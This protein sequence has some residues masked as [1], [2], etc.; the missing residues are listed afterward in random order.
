M[1]RPVEPQR[2]AQ[3][4]TKNQELKQISAEPQGELIFSFPFREA[5]D[6][7][8]NNPN[9]VAA[10][11]SRVRVYSVLDLVV[12]EIGRGN[13][14]TGLNRVAVARMSGAD[15]LEVRVDTNDVAIQIDE[16]AGDSSVRMSAAAYSGDSCC[17]VGRWL[18]PFATGALFG[19]SFVQ[20]VVTEITA[21]GLPGSTITVDGVVY[22]IGLFAFQLRPPWGSLVNPRIAT[23]A[24]VL[25]VRIERM[26]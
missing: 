24:G 12:T 8:A 18:P 9:G 20:G 10:V 11:G 7:Y 2:D 19:P 23:S 16:A 25:Q 13:I 5:L 17:G 6:V 1:A 21:V 14:L 22:P 4:V 15:K 26:T 3:L